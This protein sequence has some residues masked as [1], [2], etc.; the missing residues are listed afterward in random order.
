MIGTLLF[1]VFAVLLLAGVPIGVALGLGGAVAI[2]GGL[3]FVV[4]V[5]R[6]LRRS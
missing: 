3:L 4:V 5:V 6:A 1:L 2:V